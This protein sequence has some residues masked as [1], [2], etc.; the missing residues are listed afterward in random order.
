MSDNHTQGRLVYQENSD[1]YTH[2]LRDAEGRFI[3]QLSQDAS[4][5]SEVNAR[6]FA[7]CW[8]A[9]DGLSSKELEALP[10][11][12]AE[13]A[14]GELL[15]TRAELAAARALLDEVFKDVDPETNAQDALFDRISVFL[16]GQP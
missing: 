16:K 4:G 12:F 1:V 10:V 15:R 2:I 11:P 13:L 7:A 9:C 14:L 8:N 5:Q 3:L 6:R